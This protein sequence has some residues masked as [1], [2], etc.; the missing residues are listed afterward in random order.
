MNKPV[1]LGL[2]ILD[3]SK[4]KV[5]EFWHDCLKPKYNNKTKLRYMGTDSFIAHIKTE[6][7]YKD[8]LEDVETR[9]D[10][11][12]YNVNRPLP[13]GKK[14]KSAWVNEGWT[15]RPNYE[16]ICWLKAQNICL[17]K[18]QWGWKHKGK[19]HRKACNKKSPKFKDFKICL[20][21][22]QIINKVNYLE[23]KEIHV[24]SLKENHREFI[25]NNK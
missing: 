4:T 5:Y 21:A 17:F 6:D 14:Q 11:S 8:I 23:N 25:E 12:N 13:M 2:S 18:R 20:N 19:R 24:N 22:S 10:T 9:F 1:Y 3:I 15:S 7:I 16:E